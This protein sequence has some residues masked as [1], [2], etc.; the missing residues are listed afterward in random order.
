M[1]TFNCKIL[2]GLLESFDIYSKVHH[3]L[4]IYIVKYG[5]IDTTNFTV[6]KNLCILKSFRVWLNKQNLKNY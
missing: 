6:Q 4:V 1:T 3:N 5:R 2:D